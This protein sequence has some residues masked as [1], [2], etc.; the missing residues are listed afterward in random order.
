[1]RPPKPGSRSLITRIAFLD[2][3]LEFPQHPALGADSLA[4][5]QIQIITAPTQPVANL[6]PGFQR[7]FDHALAEVQLL[8]DL[9]VSIVVQRKLDA[10]RS[11]GQKPRA[12]PD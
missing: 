9:L 4:L 1:M 5:L 12:A 8:F 7:R 10:R 11:H 6:I 3:R 2:Q